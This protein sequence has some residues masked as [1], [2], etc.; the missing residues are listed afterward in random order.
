MEN[1]KNLFEVIEIK[2]KGYWENIINEIIQ[3]ISEGKENVECLSD[4]K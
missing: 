4:T 3:L 1:Q 2:E